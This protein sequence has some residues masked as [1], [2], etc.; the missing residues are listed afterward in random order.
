MHKQKTANFMHLVS[1]KLRHDGYISLTFLPHK[2]SS[3]VWIEHSATAEILF[4]LL[5]LF[6]SG[7]VNFSGKKGIQFLQLKRKQMKRY[8]FQKRLH[9]PIFTTLFSFRS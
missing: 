1:A 8:Y 9:Y 5:Q 6:S 7:A 2:F 4:D 3:A